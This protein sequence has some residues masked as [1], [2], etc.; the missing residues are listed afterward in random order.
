MSIPNEIL[1]ISEISTK[2]IIIDVA[3]IITAGKID[4]FAIDDKRCSIDYNRCKNLQ[5]NCKKLKNNLWKIYDNR[6][7]FTNL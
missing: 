4:V 7:K 1:E 5:E 2:A 6:W 3:A